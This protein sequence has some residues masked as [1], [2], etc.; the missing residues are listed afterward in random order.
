MKDHKSLN[1]ITCTNFWRLRCPWWWW[2][3][4]YQQQQGGHFLVVGWGQRVTRINWKLFKLNTLSLKENRE[5]SWDSFQQSSINCSYLSQ[6][7]TF[8][9][10]QNKQ[11]KSSK[12]QISQVHTLVHFNSTYVHIVMKIMK[13][14]TVTAIIA[15]FKQ[16]KQIQL[17]CC[18]IKITSWGTFCW[19][20]QATQLWCWSEPCSLFY[21][22]WLEE[23]IPFLKQPGGCLVIKKE[24]E[25]LIHL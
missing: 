1:C 7:S 15:N 22:I 19:L 25:V 12:K 6:K 9:D 24:S 11:I 2:K 16:A 10:T 23:H 4:M 8:R 21:D 14:E 17:T 5:A 20:H 3:E 18:L 13:E